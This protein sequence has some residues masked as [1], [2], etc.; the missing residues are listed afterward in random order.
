M[1]DKENL[2]A[3]GYRFGSYKDAA[4]AAEEKKKVEYFKER[5]AGRNARNLLAVYDRILDEKVFETPVGW[6][7]LKNMQETLR[8][9]GIPEDMIRPIPMYVTFSHETGEDRENTVV[10]QRIKPSRKNKTEDKLRISIMANIILVVLVLAMF[11]ITLKSDNPNILNY[12][13]AI[14]NQYASWEQEISER[15]KAVKEKERELQ[16]EAVIENDVTED[17]SFE[18]GTAESSAEE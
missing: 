17:T 1:T 7:Y 16:I 9:A 4:L 6:E 8:A 18:N 15:E 14:I 12:K 3:E 11:I 10:R 5:T 2:L 13:K